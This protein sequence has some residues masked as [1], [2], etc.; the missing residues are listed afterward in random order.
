MSEFTIDVTEF[1][2]AAATLE[3]QADRILGN[4]AEGAVEGIADAVE[5]KVRTQARRHSRTGRLVRNVRQLEAVDAGFASKATVKATGM[6]AP[7][8]IG[9]SRPHAIRPIRAHALGPL[10]GRG[11]APFASGVRHPGTRPDPFFARGVR[12]ADPESIMDRSAE[13]AADALAA[14][15]EG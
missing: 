1:T 6:V 13:L 11:P 2:A 9:G 12:D 8:I 5:A 14:A 10:T 15:V 4:V 7:I 3:G